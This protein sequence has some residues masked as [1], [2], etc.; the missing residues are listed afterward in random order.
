MNILYVWHMYGYGVNT[1]NITTTTDKVRAY[2][3]KFPTVKASIITWLTKEAALNK[4]EIT[5]DALI[6]DYDAFLDIYNKYSD[7]NE[8]VTDVLCM[9]IAD[10]ITADTGIPI[11]ACH[12]Y[13]TE[14]NIALMPSF[15]PW[16]YAS[17]P[18][19]SA[20]K[21]ED[22]IK[23]VFIRHLRLLT[24]EPIDEC[25]WGEWSVEGWA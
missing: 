20:I 5:L 8:D 6:D 7:H 22:D 1:D 2:I 4:T 12:D 17:T 16:E 13:N 23:N 9:L 25:E 11:V 15:Y 3:E 18:A 24:D 14:K 10:A 21:T 19:L